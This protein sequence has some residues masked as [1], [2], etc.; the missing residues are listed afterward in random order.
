VCAAIPDEE[1]GDPD[2]CSKGIKKH[3]I[4]ADGTY[5]LTAAGAAGGE[6]SAYL[7]LLLFGSCSM[8]LL[9][10]PDDSCP[11]WSAVS[12]S[13]ELELDLGV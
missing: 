6:F 9:H 8:V 12:V 7:N 2:S 3:T 5:K 11:A 4:K 13:L 1:I 10:D